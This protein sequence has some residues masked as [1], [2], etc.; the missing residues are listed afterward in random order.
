MTPAPPSKRPLRRASP[1][2]D[3]TPTRAAAASRALA[4]LSLAAA[5]AR[6]QPA[7][8]PPPTPPDRAPTLAPWAETPPPRRD[9]PSPEGEGDALDASEALPVPVARRWPAR[10]PARP[11]EAAEYPWEPGTSLGASRRVRETPDLGVGAYFQLPTARIVRYGDVMA[12]YLSALGWLGARYGLT[13][14]VDVGLGVPYYLYGLSVDA[15]V[16]FYEREGFAAAWWGMATVPFRGDADRATD[17]LGFTWNFAGLGWAS[18]PLVTWWSDRLALSGGLHLAQRTGLGGVWLMGHVTADL[19]L[20]NGV[21]LLAQGFALAEL[22]RESRARAEALLGDGG[23]RVLP[24]AL[25][26]VRFYTR[27]FSADLGL[28]APLSPAAPLYTERLG[29]L[30]WVSLSHLF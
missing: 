21:K 24:Y 10:R 12:H 1:R 17:C 2:T 15:R 30:P 26:G 23:R 8:A 18:G 28:L 11:R 5:Q 20:V 22:S 27:R 13:R 19:R 29:V 9:A 14:R 16:L 6:A 4:A 25:G 7:P 3:V